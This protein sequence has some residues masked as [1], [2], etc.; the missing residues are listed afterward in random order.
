MEKSR[1]L[2]KVP[3]S[4][5]IQIWGSDVIFRQDKITPKINP[6]R[7]GAEPDQNVFLAAELLSVSLSFDLFISQS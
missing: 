7:F 3:I 4:V 6:L 2:E 5:K 1:H